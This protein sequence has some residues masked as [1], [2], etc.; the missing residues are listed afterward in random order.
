VI[1]RGQPTQTI[2]NALR[3][4]GMVDELVQNQHLPVDWA[5]NLNKAVFGADFTADSKSYSGGP[6]GPSR[7]DAIWLRNRHSS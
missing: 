2:A 5:I 1:D 7:R 4:D 6:Y 3:P